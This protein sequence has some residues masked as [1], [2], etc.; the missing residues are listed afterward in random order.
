MLEIEA[1]RELEQ[2][3]DIQIA[4]ERATRIGH[5]EDAMMG[6][7]GDNT[8]GKAVD[9]PRRGGPAPE[10]Y[11]SKELHLRI[12]NLAGRVSKVEGIIE[13]LFWG[14]RNRQTEKSREGAA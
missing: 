7:P 5:P 10:V 3:A 14:G 13:G 4:L 12:S 6:A 1:E 9:S 2:E 8:A 11:V